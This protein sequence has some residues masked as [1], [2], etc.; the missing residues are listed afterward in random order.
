MRRERG[1]KR[2]GPKPSGTSKK[3]L[4][5]VQCASG[6]PWRPGSYK[7]RSD[8]R[9]VCLVCIAEKK[10]DLCPA[11]LHARAEHE[12]AYG[13]CR[14]CAAVRQVA[15]R[16]RAK[17]GLTV[18][19]FE[20][21]LAEQDYRCAIC[22]EEF[23]LEKHNGVCVDHDHACCPGETTCGKCLRKIL[24]GDCNLGLG[25]FKDSETLLRAAADYLAATCRPRQTSIVCQNR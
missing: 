20:E 10:G 18:E 4:K 17:Y 15:Q 21:M 5:L 2:P 13:Q 3:A 14:P 25:R 24:C 23:D 1:L 9:K 6:H 12:N 16:L 11:G 7:E 22:R 8:G 19:Q